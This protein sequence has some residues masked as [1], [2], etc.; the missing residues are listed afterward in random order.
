MSVSKKA[1]RRTTKSAKAKA[2]KPRAQVNAAATSRTDARVA[3]PQPTGPRAKPKPADEK[4]IILK[5]ERD[6]NLLYYVKTSGAAGRD[7]ADVWTVAPKVEGAPRPT[8][9][10]ITSLGFHVDLDKFLYLVDGDGDVSRRMRTYR[11]KNEQ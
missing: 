5:L 8:P 2:P 9:K 1:T 7:G 10:R 11:R 6:P 4:Y 3:S